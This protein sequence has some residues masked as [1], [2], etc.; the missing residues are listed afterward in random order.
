MSLHRYFIQLS[1][2]G[3]DFHGW[4]IQPNGNTVQA[5]LNRALTQLNSNQPINV[6]GCGRTDTGVH[7]SKFF[8]HFDFS[9]PIDLDHFKFKLNN[10]L[11]KSIAIQNISLVNEN[12]H[13]RFDAIERTYHYHI[14]NTKNPFLVDS[15]L[16][17]TQTLNIERMNEVSQLLLNHTD[18]ECFS[19][20]KT[21]VS[22]FNCKVTKAIWHTTENG[23]YFEITA[24]RFLRNMVRAIVGTLLEIGMGNISVK[25]FDRILHSKDRSQAGKSVLPNGLFLADIKYPYPL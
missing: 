8:A 9:M 17:V 16:M 23:Y 2:K 3:T 18:F 22:N 10:M 1:Y 14:H 24:N 7:A 11:P 20:V 25:D 5:E 6:V 13:A 4:Q 12:A 15:S 19:K 21:D